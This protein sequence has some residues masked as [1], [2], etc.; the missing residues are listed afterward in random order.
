MA[1][2]ILQIENLRTH[3]HLKGGTLR[4][5][6]GLSLTLEEGK[7][8]CIVGESGSGK[9]VTALSIMGLVMPPGRVEDGRIAFRGTDLLTLSEKEMRKIRGNNIGMIFQDPMHALNPAFR[10]GDQ[11]AETML[12]H[13]DIGKVE[14]KERA[15]ELL[16]H[17]GIAQ[18]DRRY[19]DY[20]HQ[21]SGGMRQ[22]VMIA[23]AIACH[24]DLLI[25]DEPTTALDVTIQAQ[26]LN[27]LS[28][29]RAELKSAMILITHDLGV[30]AEMADDV[31]VMYAGQPV[32][33]GDVETLFHRPQ[34]PYTRGLLNSLI[35]LSD[36]RE[37][38]LKPIP[39]TPA[40]RARHAGGLSLPRPLRLCGG[41]LR[42]RGSSPSHR[43]RRASGGVPSRGR[44]AWPPRW[45][46]AMS[47]PLL[48]VHDL[49]K[50]FTLERKRLLQL[51]PDRLRAVDGVSFD[52]ARGDT[53]GLVGESGC[54]K[55]TTAR[56]ILR[57]IEPT[58]G[59]VTLDGV[60]VLGSSGGVLRRLRREMQIVFQDPLSSLNPRMTVG[61]N[62]AIQLYYHGIGNR[63]ERIQQAS[64]L[65]EVVGLRAA[66]YDRYPH[67][68]SGGQCQRV[69][70]ARALLLRPKLIIFD[71]PVSALDVSIRAQIL[72]LLL[73][74]QQDY[75]LTYIF[76]S[77]DLSVV[78]RVCDRTA[79]MYLGRI[80]ELAE[81]ERL[82][83]EPLHP[84]TQALLES[85]PSAEPTERHIA[86]QGAIEGDVPSPIDPPKGCHFH[87]RCPKR[88]PVCSEREP[89]LMD[90]GGNHRV[91]CLLYE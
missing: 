5:V 69:A 24:P 30:V 17:V 13:L 26:I 14:A 19:V 2:P 67:E 29:L 41:A 28:A 22:R 82:Y 89:P 20:P 56:L 80:V 15:I 40:R 36:H 48:Q 72:Q 7:V 53:L 62:I 38:R 71:E 46:R 58:S 32:E 23:S 12:E 54:G 77:H 4:A 61:E 86:G 64:E 18:P 10:I 16:G 3:F 87:T 47:T 39:G 50:H 35:R 51:H 73:E 34:H 37:T 57:L 81:S 68:F 75:Q 21:F 63:L 49:V 44:G 60:D 85:I 27:L 83:D 79:V 6:D 25:A 76:I 9:S 90:V 70:I 88:M 52:V 42:E 74:L 1:A 8:L 84:Y 78:K 11:I 33:Y 45:G 43:T 66:D 91:A 65:L 31:M 59:S 55:S